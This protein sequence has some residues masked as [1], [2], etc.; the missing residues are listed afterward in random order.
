MP[1]RGAWSSVSACRRGGLLASLCL[2]PLL[3][4]AVRG[5]RT[6]IYASRLL[7]LLKITEQCRES[8][9]EKRL[10]FL[11]LF[12]VVF[13]CIGAPRCCSVMMNHS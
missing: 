10:S 8:L 5:R 1:V 3:G 13:V 4:L 7:Q 2:S 9:S 11:S 6:Y 12:F